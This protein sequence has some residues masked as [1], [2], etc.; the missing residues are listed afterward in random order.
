MI[1]QIEPMN[2]SQPWLAAWSW[3]L[4]LGVALLLGIGLRLVWGEDMEYKLDEWWTYER[5]QEI[6]D[7]EPLPWLGMPTSAGFL[8]PGGTVWIFYAL[9]KLTG[10]HD[11]VQLARACQLLNIGALLLLVG[12]AFF[13]VPR[14]QR[15]P[16]LWAAALVAVNPLAVLMH[17]KIWPPSVIPALTMLL[18]ITYWYRDRRLGAFAWGIAGAAIGAFYPAAMFLAAGFFLWA[19]LF[20]RARVAWRWWLPGSMLGV[21][22]LIPWFWYVFTEMGTRT[23]SHRRWAHLVEGKFW[24]YWVTEPF[25]IS[26]HYSL[27]ADFADFLSY[28]HCFGVP[29]YL[30]GMMHGV[31]VLAAVAL[32]AGLVRRLWRERDRWRDLWIGRDSQTAF[33]QN[34]CLW[35]FGLVFTAT[36]LS[37]YRHYMVIT[38]PLMFLWLARAALAH[39]RPLAGSLST[40]R[41]FL[42]GLCIA[43]LVIT[44]SF[45]GYIHV[46]Q[47]TIQ[48]DYATPYAAQPRE[49]SEYPRP[50]PAG[51]TTASATAA[52]CP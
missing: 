13:S 4:G 30:V 33:T 47:R 28:P 22:P 24:L 43:Q 14:E 18:I 27:G 9:A 17:R 6:N 51:M 11:P 40:G 37:V 45:L 52:T 32:V 41:V 3:R 23:P 16:W 7:G 29:T 44:A 2:R 48:G 42:V 49:G 1:T 8:H 5:V 26:L 35:G 12:F 46:N 15:E 36:M 21:L 19:L 20:D 10:A 50:V 38:F 34:A 25:G 31:I 39:R